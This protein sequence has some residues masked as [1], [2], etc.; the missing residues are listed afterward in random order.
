MLLKCEDNK[1]AGEDKDTAGKWRSF[2]ILEAFLF[3]SGLVKV[4]M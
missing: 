3:I 4:W 1:E 2:Y